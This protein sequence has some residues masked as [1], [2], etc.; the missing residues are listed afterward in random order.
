MADF[1]RILIFMGIA[2]LI[3]GGTLVLAQRFFPMLGNLPGDFRFERE[4]GSF[5]FP[6]ATM[7]ILSIVGSVLLNII[8]RLFK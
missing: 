4:G 2:L 6:L 8:L 1:G 5:Y 3:V 7:L